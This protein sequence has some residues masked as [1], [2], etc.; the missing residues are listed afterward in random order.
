MEKAGEWIY[1]AERQQEQ[2]QNNSNNNNKNK[3]KNKLNQ[4]Q[5]QNKDLHRKEEP[6]VNSFVTITGQFSVMI[7]TLLY[8]FGPCERHSELTEEMYHPFETDTKGKLSSSL[9]FQKTGQLTE[10]GRP[11]YL[12]LGR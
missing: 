7:R 5:Q 12:I 10:T 11:K 6:R 4:K 9:T 3:Q 1:Q 2:Q 8:G